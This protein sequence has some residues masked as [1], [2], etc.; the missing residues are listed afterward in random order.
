MAGY[1]AKFKVGSTARMHAQRLQHEEAHHKDHR[2]MGARHLIHL[3]DNEIEISQE[4]LAHL[5]AKGMQKAC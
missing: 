1:T 4:A 3:P 5:C 2:T